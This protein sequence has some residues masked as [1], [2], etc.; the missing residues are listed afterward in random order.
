MNTLKFKQYGNI[1]KKTLWSN[2]EI[3]TSN[4]EIHTIWKY[5]QAIWKYIQEDIKR[6]SKIQPCKKIHN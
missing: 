5:I 1:Y 6:K 3:Y 2:M 4:M